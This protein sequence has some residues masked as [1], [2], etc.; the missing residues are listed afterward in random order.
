MLSIL[1]NEWAQKGWEVI[2]LTMED[3]QVEPFYPLARSI[4]LR[5]L[6][7]LKD[8]SSFL[9]AIWNN[10]KRVWILRQAIKEVQP[11]VL[12]SFIDKA[13]ALAILAT[14]GLGIPVI[15]SER[16]DPSRRSLGR[17]WGRIRD[18]AYP[19]ADLIVFQSQGVLD[20]FPSRVRA[21]GVVIPNPVP[22]PPPRSRETPRKGSGLCIVSLG[23]LS[24]VKGF[25]VLVTAFAKATARVPH[26]RLDVWG[27][28]PER[29]PLEQMV[30]ALGMA[31]QIQFRGITDRPFD[32][33]RGAD[34]FVLPSRAEGFPNALVEAMACGLPVISTR[35]GGAAMDII[36]DGSNG[37][38]VPPGEPQ[39]LADA[40][41]RL[42]VDP[43]ERA[44]LGERAPEVVERFSTKRV[45]AMWEHAVGQVIASGR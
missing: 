36:V 10:I 17:P 41:V 42:M 24:P 12:I 20:W 4:E 35:F 33:L 19:R 37:L 29:K 25:D 27:E 28:G 21:R 44:R 34:L 30:S 6:H 26:W 23:R 16:T 8:S 9:S 11:D 32:I 13:N 31:G 18:L 15:I 38:L 14:R 7:L 40:L 22:P 39:A 5:P 45:L 1:A 3:H 43:H 2:V